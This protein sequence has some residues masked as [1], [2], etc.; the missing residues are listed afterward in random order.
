MRTPLFLPALGA[1]LL[2]S[3]C[4]D[5]PTFGKNAP[6]GVHPAAN[7]DHPRAET[8][9]ARDNQRE[10]ARDSVREPVREPAREPTRD[11]AASLREGIRLYNNGDFNNAIVKLNA[12]E[13]QS[14][15]AATRI[16]ALKYSAFS[17]CVTQRPVQ[18]RQSFDKA[19]RLD[20]GFVLAPGEEGHPMW[21]P[22]FQKA[23]ASR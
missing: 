13:I 15:N 8:V 16:S 4:A 1:A 9:L 10:A 2:L 14:A 3:A 7:A 6:G 20:A 17:Y 21:G 19:L 23:R 18:C 11:A 22:V 12:P 5:L